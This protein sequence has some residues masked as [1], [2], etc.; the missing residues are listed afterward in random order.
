MT[1]KFLFI[2][3]LFKLGLN[4]TSFQTQPLINLQTHIVQNNDVLTNDKFEGTDDFSP[5]LLFFSIFALVFVLVCVGAG[6]VLTLLILAIVFGLIATGIISASLVVGVYKKSF[7]KGFKTFLISSSTIGFMIFGT[8]GFW[9]LNKIT[10]W[11]T[12]SVALLTGS[13]TG[14][15][16]GLLFGFLAYYIIQ[17]FSVLLKNKLKSNQ[18]TDN[19]K[20]N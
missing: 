9:I 11:W 10:H 14:I 16:S 7:T 20:I 1:V 2:V 6:I 19:L 3:I 17:R 13:L 8:L 4:S 15:I 18:A 12:M 5:G